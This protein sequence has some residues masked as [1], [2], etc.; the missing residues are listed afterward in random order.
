MENVDPI[1]LFKKD[2]NNTFEFSPFQTKACEAIINKNHVLVTAH[3]G[4]GKTLPAEFAIYYYVNIVKKRVVYT[5]PI[6]ALSNQ[7]YKEFKEKFPTMEV[8]ILTGD[9]KHNPE[10]NILIMT[11]EILQNNC[12]KQKNRGLYLDFQMNMEEDLGC[13]IF[14]EVHYIDDMDR[15]TIWE[16]TMMMLPNHIPYVMLSATIGQK[17]MFASWVQCMTHKPVVICHHNERVVPLTFYEYFTLPRKYVDTIQDKKKKKQF[18]DKTSHTL[19]VV[20]TPHQYYYPILNETKKCVHELNKDRYK[21]PQKFVLNECLRELRDNDL[22]PCLLFVFSRKQVEHLAQQITTPLYLENEKESVIE[23]YVRQ[24]MVRTFSNWREYVGLPEYRFY[25]DL[26]EKG[27]G[28]HHAGML[29]IFRE[30]MEILYEKKFIKCLVATE[31]FAIGLNMPTRTVLFHSLYKHDGAQMRLLQSHEF[32]QMAGRAGRRNLDK[33]GHVILLNNLY[34][35]LTENEYER[36]FHGTPKVLKSKFRITYHLLLN[37]LHEYGEEDFVSMVQ[38]SMMNTDIV[39]QIQRSEDILQELEVKRVECESILDSLGSDMS[40]FFETH[41]SMVEKMKRAKNKERKTLSRAL[42]QMEEQEGHK[43]KQKPFYDKMIELKDK[44][45]KETKTKTYAQG[46]ISDQIHGLYHILGLN[47]FMDDSLKP[48]Q[49]ALNACYIHEIPCLVFSDFYEEF[50]KLEPYSEIQLICLLSCFYDLKVKDDYK[51][52]YPPFLKKELDYIE[53]KTNAYM[54]H[55]LKYNLYITCQYKLQY[56]LMIYIKKWYEEVDNENQSRLFF[57]ELKSELDVFIGDFMK[58]CMKIV[59][60]CNELKIFGEN[61]GNYR[62]VEKIIDIQKKI[63]KNIVT[64]Q[65]FYL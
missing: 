12:F 22:F 40:A 26:L 37:Y 10:A 30:I 38:T 45:D 44:I 33:V 60:M 7:K 25:I 19:R 39:A 35:P 28:V 65:S 58:C 9:I 48:T 63:Q 29:P 57:Q 2:T 17:E 61:D 41:A 36:L 5:S 8:G 46:Y 52:H 6:K 47:G 23:P 43:L 34:E 16:Q 50:D 11:T 21:V 15:G 24:T 1:S 64:N 42:R 3:T 53:K 18:L 59:N 54:D 14:D 4:S 56:D 49:K 31:T 62:F 55:E 32:T 27:V 20:K 51:T 13:V